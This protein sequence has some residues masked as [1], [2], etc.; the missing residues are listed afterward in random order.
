MYQNN[1]FKK[2]VTR[3]AHSIPNDSHENYFL[4]DTRN[5]PKNKHFLPPDTCTF[6]YGGVEG[7]VTIVS[8]L[9]NFVYVLNEWSHKGLEI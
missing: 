1:Y 9:D 8:F 6:A 7:G 5:Y 3:V 2:H 4:L